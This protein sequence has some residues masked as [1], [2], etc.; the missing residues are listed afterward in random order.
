MKYGK[1]LL[2]ALPS[3]W[4]GTIIYLICKIWYYFEIN[5]PI[6][7]FEGRSKNKKRRPTEESCCPICNERLT[8]T[9]EELNGHV[10]LCLK[11]VGICYV[12]WR[13]FFQI[14]KLNKIFFTK[15]SNHFYM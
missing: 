15:L 8:G 9:A 4:V 3:H 5:S 6:L 13:F 10:E 12:F 11:R 14:L 7:H 2:N 1:E